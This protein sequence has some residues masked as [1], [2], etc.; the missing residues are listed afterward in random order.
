MKNTHNRKN[1]IF[2]RVDSGQKIGYGHLIR[3]M[4][5]GDKLKKNWHV[6]FVTSN[7]KGNITSIVKNNFQDCIWRFIESYNKR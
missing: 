6:F 7:I 1:T 3:C 5:L 2:I 4:A